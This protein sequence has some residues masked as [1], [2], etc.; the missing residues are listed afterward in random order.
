MINIRSQ[1]MAREAEITVT[2]R[3][4]PPRLVRANA[5]KCELDVAEAQRRSLYL[6]MYCLQVRGLFNFAE[7]D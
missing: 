1:G 3:L 6:F 5:E 4:K 2:H 7:P